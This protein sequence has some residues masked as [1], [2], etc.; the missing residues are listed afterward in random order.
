MPSVV[1]SSEVVVDV[2]GASDALG[3]VGVVGGG[4]EAGRERAGFVG[5][6][7]QVE[8][9]AVDGDELVLDEVGLLGRDLEVSAREP[10]IDD[11]HWSP[12]RIAMASARSAA[13]RRAVS[14]SIPSSSRTLISVGP[15]VQSRGVRLRK[16]SIFTVP[17]VMVRA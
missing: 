5:E 7:L 3:M 13:T 10:G 4:D 14:T 11:A 2:V 9:G 8:A 6:Q 16:T 15:N 17:C 1:K 12:L